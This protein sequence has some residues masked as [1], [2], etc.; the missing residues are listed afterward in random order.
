MKRI[1]LVSLF[2]LVGIFFSLSGKITEAQDL[3]LNL[4]NWSTYMNPEILTEFEKKFAV[5][6]QSDT[7]DSTEALYAKLKP[8]NPG[9]D[10]IFPSDYGVSIMSKEKL[11]EPINLANIPNIKHQD[12]KFIN[13]PFD[14]KN[15]Y[16]F[17]Y[18]WGTMGLGYNYKK[19]GK[20][21]ESWSQVFDSQMNGKVALLNE[22][23]T[24]LGGI[25]IYLGYDPNT[26]KAEEINKARDFLI[27]HK[28]II[29]AFANDNG[30]DLLNQGEVE[31][32]VEWSGDVFQ[33][34]EQNADI[35]YSIPSEGS[36][37]WLDN[38][39]IPKNAPHKALAEKFI[40]FMLTPEIAAKNANFLKYA[41]PNK[42]A[43][44]NN[45]IN[46]ELKKNPAIYPSPEVFN[47]LVY[48]K[49]VGEA[50]KLYDQAWNDLK[51][52]TSN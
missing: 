21:V 20:V 34:M 24:M 29:V 31:L 32:A 4:Y 47:K 35:R 44:E 17:P 8:G 36:V 7:Y 9:Y 11:L 52:E 48:I 5:K 28:D 22:L 37:V 51:L 10:V 41:T 30:Q 42:T 49:D 3:T 1:L 33:V 46:P 12:K 25:L 19:T 6:I 26:T 27:K 45:L 14:P 16:S 23:R 15:Q 18:L 50:N 39:A 40:N 13:V 43:L 38:M 2:F